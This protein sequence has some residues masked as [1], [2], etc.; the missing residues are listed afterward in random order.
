MRTES[1]I[2]AMLVVLSAVFEAVP[3]EVRRRAV[4]MIEGSADF[5][6]DPDAKALMATYGLV[7]ASARI[8]NPKPKKARRRRA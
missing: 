4:A 7:P 2:K 5:V 6:D 1:T 3:P 8:P